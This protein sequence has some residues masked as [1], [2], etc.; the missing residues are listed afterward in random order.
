MFKLYWKE[1]TW[2]CNVILP[3]DPS[4]QE[5]LLRGLTTQPVRHDTPVTVDHSSD[6]THLK[7]QVH[8]YTIMF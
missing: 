4:V 8:I 7:L 3:F 2:M 6:V 5:K 1:E